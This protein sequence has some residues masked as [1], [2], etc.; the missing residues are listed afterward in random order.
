MRVVREA[1]TATL[2]V[3]VLRIASPS[4]PAEARQFVLVAP[5]AR[6]MASVD[7]RPPPSNVAKTC[8]FWKL[9]DPAPRRTSTLAPEKPPRVASKVAPVTRVS[10][11]AA[12]GRLPAPIAMPFSVV[13][14]LLPLAPSI[15]R[16][17][18]AIV[19][20]GIV[21]MVVLMSPAIVGGTPLTT[22]SLKRSLDPGS[23]TVGETPV[24]TRTGLF[25][26]IF[27]ASSET[28][29]LES[30]KSATNSRSEP[31]RVTRRRAGL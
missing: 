9:R 1:S 22:P 30:T 25:A 31:M 23:W 17:P 24:D 7:W 16:P 28:T 29:L 21:L 4:M 15:D 11:R 8:R 26:A 10:T 19:A 20:P 13:R 6:P 18:P 14:L 2:Y 27:T 12:R 3:S 5:S